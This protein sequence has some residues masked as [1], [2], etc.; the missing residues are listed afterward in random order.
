MRAL[1]CTYAPQIRDFLPLPCEAAS[2]K[3]VYSRDRGMVYVY[4]YPHREYWAAVKRRFPYW[5]ELARKIDAA[6]VVDGV[7]CPIFS[8]PGKLLKWLMSLRSGRVVDER[9]VRL[10]CKL[11]GLDE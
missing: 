9:I 6:C 11:C 1:K 7:H 10:A 5:R 8:T 2:V 3:R 4:A